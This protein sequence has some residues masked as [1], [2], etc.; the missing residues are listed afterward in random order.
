M[1]ILALRAEDRVRER[2][3]LSQGRSGDAI[4]TMVRRALASRHS[5]GGLLL[6]VGCGSGQLWRYVGK[7][8][9]R[10]VGIDAVRY[11]DFPVDGQFIAADLDEMPLPLPDQYA[12]V[13]G[14][15]EA[16]EHLENPRAFAREL[17]RIVKPGGIV[18]LTTPNNLS[19]LSLMTLTLKHR[20]SAFQ[21]VHYPAHL[22][23]LL[24]IDLRRIGAECGLRDVQILYSHQGRIIFTPWHF[25]KA[26][27][28]L[29]PSA[30][31]DNLL[32]V[33]TR[34]NG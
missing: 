13:V 17:T 5:G 16:I 23:A 18:I 26:L 21:D 12:D 7:S 30:L 22:T 33:G 24:E 14:A 29:S 34:A 8:F 9:S 32:L 6:D 28:R 1:T 31:S 15:V 20:F 2:S 10:Y 25:P 11:E 4:Y 19:L 3:L 27:S